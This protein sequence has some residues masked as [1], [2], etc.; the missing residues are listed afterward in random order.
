MNFDDFW[1]K[2]PPRRGPNPKQAARKA[3][4][5]AVKKT[6]PEHIVQAAQQFR[7]ECLQ[8]DTFDTP[9]IPHARTWLNQERY[10]DYGY[11]SSVSSGDNCSVSVSGDEHSPDGNCPD[12][13]KIV[14]PREAQ[15]PRWTRIK[16][17]IRSE[18]GEASW[19]VWGQQVRLVAFDDGFPVFVCGS[20]QTYGWAKR[21]LEHRLMVLWE[22]E[23]L[24]ISG[25]DFL[26]RPSDNVVPLRSVG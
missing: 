6:T 14:L 24:E 1:Q 22:S 15:D 11:T 10:L 9:F 4:D 13:E 20:E 18:I 7:D 26:R 17:R 2:Y 21:N 19:K 25:F 12:R 5:K 16:A 23:G 8:C 3:W